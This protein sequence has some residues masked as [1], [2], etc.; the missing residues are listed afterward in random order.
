MRAG[1]LDLFLIIV[2]L[3]WFLNILFYLCIFYAPIAFLNTP[4]SVF[5]ICSAE[6]SI[7]L[8]L[9]ILLNYKLTMIE[10]WWFVPLKWQLSAQVTKHQLNAKSCQGR[11]WEQNPE[12][13]CTWHNSYISD[14][15]VLWILCAVLV[16]PKKVNH[17]WKRFRN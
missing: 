7:C 1:G 4:E 2:K 17:N 6:Y 15:H 3:P 8:C 9:Q 16:S 11:N 13:N 12:C 10:Q 5:N 14:A